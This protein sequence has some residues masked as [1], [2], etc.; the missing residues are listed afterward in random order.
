MNEDERL[1]QLLEGR[2]PELEYSVSTVVS[3]DIESSRRFAQEIVIQAR[4]QTPTRV[5]N[6]ALCFL[7]TLA[8]LEAVESE[9]QALKTKQ[10]T[11]TKEPTS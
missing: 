5:G 8:D 4:N 2:I 9:L 10:L 6:M 3:K 1:I 11:P 7:A